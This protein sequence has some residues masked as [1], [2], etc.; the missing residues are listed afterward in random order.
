MSERK[1][2]PRTITKLETLPLTN[3]DISWE[4]W[5]LRTI[6]RH[7]GISFKELATEFN[8]SPTYVYN[9][10]NGNRLN[11]TDVRLW[12]WYEEIDDALTR[13]T[14]RRGGVPCACCGVEGYFAMID[15]LSKSPIAREE[16]GVR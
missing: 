7:R 10:M 9:L 8:I 2:D 14:D 15:E 12:K 6:A 16:F 13:I 11:V 4:V 3:Y 1:T 5:R